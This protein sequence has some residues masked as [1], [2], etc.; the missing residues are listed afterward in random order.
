M[1]D[2]DDGRIHRR[3]NR[4]RHL[5]VAFPVDSYDYQRA[6]DDALIMVSILERMIQKLYDRV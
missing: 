4:D 3:I 2:L 6:N 5:P 1:C